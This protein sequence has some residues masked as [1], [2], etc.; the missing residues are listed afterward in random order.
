MP[1]CVTREREQLASQIE[2]LESGRVFQERGKREIATWL[3]Q[4]HL[5]PDIQKELEEL[6]VSGLGYIR[7]GLGL[8]S[9]VTPQL[10]C[11]IPHVLYRTIRIEAKSGC[12]QCLCGLRLHRSAN[13]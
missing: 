12:C 6:G 11:M 4:A 8:L 3:S 9:S 2:D 10:L 13:A 7:I 1:A 5:P